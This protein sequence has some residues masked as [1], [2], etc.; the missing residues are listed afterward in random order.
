MLEIRL[1]GSNVVIEALTTVQYTVVLTDGA[2]TQT[3]GPISFNLAA[4]TARWSSFAQ[5]LLFALR[6]TLRAA[7]AAN[8]NLSIPV[9][10]FPNIDL[11]VTPTPGAGTLQIEYTFGT[12]NTTF[13]ASSLPAV[14]QSISLNNST[15][16]WSKVGLAAEVVTPIAAVITGGQGSI[17]S[18]F[19]P[20]SIFCFE[21]SEI[22]TGDYEQVSAYATHRLANGKVRSYDLGS[23]I[24]TR[25]YTLVDQ[26]YDM[27]G[28]AVHIGLLSSS[29]INGARDTLNFT[30]FTALPNQTGTGLTN[31]GYTEELVELNRYISIGGR[32]V[33]R[34]R[35]KTATSIQL[36]DKVPAGIDVTSQIE[37]TQVSEAH[38]VWFEAVR[39]GTLHVYGMDETTGQ[40]Y[41]NAASY[42]L[43]SGESNFQ[44]TRLDIGN[45]LYSKTF[46]LIKKELPT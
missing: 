23:H 6:S 11:E 10:V 15:G 45:A 41:Y 14:Y 16:A 43:A 29:P 9:G 18:V 27:A 31:P 37:I 30:D 42:A 24:M 44:P 12:T 40:P 4:S 7:I 19:Q 1:L 33:G 46:D 36:W 2:L 26:D 17:A 28:P 3:L 35:A 20:R 32:W 13:V 25:T 34:V 38:A 21:R 8:A 22:D 5:T 39:L